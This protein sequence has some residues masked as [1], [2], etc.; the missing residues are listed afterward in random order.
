MTDVRSRTMPAQ[1][2]ETQ[3][4]CCQGLLGG[5]GN[6]KWSAGASVLVAS[7]DSPAWA[8][9]RR[10]RGAGRWGWSSGHKAARFIPTHCP[11]LGCRVGLPSQ[12]S[13]RL[14]PGCPAHRH[15]QPQHLPG[16][17]ARSRQTCARHGSSCARLLGK[18]V[19]PGQTRHFSEHSISWLSLRS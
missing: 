8:S 2:S 14:L 10:P 18:L 19:H 5:T 15:V 3:G 1:L 4:L 16:L 12:H 9:C 7:W 13:L 11:Q 6:R 17:A